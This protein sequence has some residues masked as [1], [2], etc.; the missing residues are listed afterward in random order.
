MVARDGGL[1]PMFRE[2]MR[3]FHWTSIETGSTGRGVPDSN[4]CAPGGVEGWVEYKQTKT[5]A[6]ALRPEQVAWLVK[7]STAGGR[8]FV[9]VRQWYDGPRKGKADRLYLFDGAYARHLLVN[10]LKHHTSWCG[11][12]ALMG[13]DGPRCW[14]WDKV[15][16]RLLGRSG[17]PA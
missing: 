7:R 2:H 10:G 15:R 4:Y 5:D 12:W 16:D 3:D 9:A 14:E 17:D 6:V 13:Y 11:R 1:R 8:C